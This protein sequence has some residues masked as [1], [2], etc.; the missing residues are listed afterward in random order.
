VNNTFPFDVDDKFWNDVI[1]QLES[2]THYERDEI[3]RGLTFMLGRRAR[4]LLE[5]LRGE[6]A[7]D[8]MEELRI[9]IV[10]SR[11]DK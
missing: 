7:D 11:E 8:V 3:E 4:T 6:D 1:E 9:A 5:Q 10:H 2:R